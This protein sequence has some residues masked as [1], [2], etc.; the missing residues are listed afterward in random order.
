MVS[1]EPLDVELTLD[2]QARKAAMSA[3][4]ESLPKAFVARVSNGLGVL[5]GLRYR[6]Q[7]PR[8]IAGTI[9]VDSEAIDAD[10]ANELL[11]EVTRSPLGQC[12]VFELTLGDGRLQ[13]LVVAPRT[14][15]EWTGFG[16]AVVALS[17][18]SATKWRV[19]YR[20]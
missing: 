17:T 3:A 6:L 9:R 19:S 5:H 7:E 2:L 14:E 11:R 4:M 12:P 8:A 20:G 16:I 10:A 13:L 1:G 15:L 18:W